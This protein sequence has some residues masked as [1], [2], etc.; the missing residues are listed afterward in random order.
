MPS[1]EKTIIEFLSPA[2]RQESVRQHVCRRDSVSFDKMRPVAGAGYVIFEIIR[3]LS[4]AEPFS[5]SGGPGSR[6]RQYPGCSS[7]SS[8]HPW[9]AGQQQPK[10]TAPSVV[11]AAAEEQPK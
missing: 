7:R 11:Q 4:A 5:I 6:N 10:Q 1:V 2:W 3:D 8:Q 9:R